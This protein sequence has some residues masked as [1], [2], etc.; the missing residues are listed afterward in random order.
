MELH[1][2]WVATLRAQV[3]EGLRKGFPP[4]L[5]DGHGRRRGTPGVV[6]GTVLSSCGACEVADPSLASNSFLI[7]T[8]ISHATRHQRVY[9]RARKLGFALSCFL[10][11]IGSRLR[12][13]IRRNFKAYA[14][15][16]SNPKENSTLTRAFRISQFLRDAQ[17]RGNVAKARERG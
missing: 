12:A 9:L 11:Y 10:T 15:K 5:V 16:C 17:E 7:A 14:R 2:S 6:W 3:H 8:L 1:V 13:H 4:Q